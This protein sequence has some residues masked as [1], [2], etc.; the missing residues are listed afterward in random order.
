MEAN[1]NLKKKIVLVIGLINPSKN[2]IESL[3]KKETPKKHQETRCTFGTKVFVSQ[4]LQNYFIE[5]F[6]KNTSNLQ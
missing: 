5:K 3:Q 6:N 1:N 2:N 4:T